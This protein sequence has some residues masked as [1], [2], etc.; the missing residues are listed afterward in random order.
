MEEWRESK[1]EANRLK[2][3]TYY[4]NHKEEISAARK[5][6]RLEHGAVAA[7]SSMSPSPSN[8]VDNAMSFFPS[9]M[10]KKRAVAKAKNA[11]PNSPHKRTEVLA[12]LL[13]SPNTR[14]SLS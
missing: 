14:K 4:Q 11:I 10:A 6:K 2:S 3:R 12:A 1:K 5:Q 8:D 13:D 7:E 9:W